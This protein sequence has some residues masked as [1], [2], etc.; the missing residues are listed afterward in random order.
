M[1]RWLWFAPVAS[2]GTQDPPRPKGFETFA[3]LESS[4]LVA[5]RASLSLAV[6]SSVYLQGSQNDSDRRFQHV[7]LQRYFQEK[8]RR[9][10]TIQQILRYIPEVLYLKMKMLT[11]ANER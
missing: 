5:P 11:G 10:Q 1:A 7:V 9:R 2:F 3:V 8:W 4:A 6:A